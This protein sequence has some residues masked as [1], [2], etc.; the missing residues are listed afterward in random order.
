MTTPYM[1]SIILVIADAVRHRL[2]SGQDAIQNVRPQVARSYI[3]ITRTTGGID[4]LWFETA[5]MEVR[6]LKDP[7][8]FGRVSRVI[9]RQPL[10]KSP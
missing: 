5:W 4:K 10:E 8:V 3:A 2:S 6:M 1:R 7:A 9:H